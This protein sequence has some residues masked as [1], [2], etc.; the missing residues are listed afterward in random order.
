MERTLKKGSQ[1]RRVFRTGMTFR[2]N[3]FRAVYVKNTLG[4]IR[5]G[6]SLSAKSGNA[7][8][9]NLVRRRIKTLARENRMRV[10]ADIVILPAGRLNDTDWPGI[11]EDFEKKMI[12]LERKSDQETT[13][14]K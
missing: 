1:F 4:Y 6:F 8:I 10:G 5:L 7:V 12:T 9:R 2:G 11:R 14:E 13:D 3:S